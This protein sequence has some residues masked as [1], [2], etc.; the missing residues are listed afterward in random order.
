MQYDNLELALDV[1]ENQ[2]G[3]P[4]L[5]DPEVTATTI[6][7]STKVSKMNEAVESYLR[8]SI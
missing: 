2:M 8:T 7:T 6:I 4:R 3:I 1:A 5:L